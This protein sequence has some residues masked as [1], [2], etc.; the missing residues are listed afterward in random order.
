MN[1]LGFESLASSYLKA[2]NIP[3]K[4]VYLPLD[5]L[6]MKLG[7]TDRPL[8]FMSFRRSATIVSISWTVS[9]LIVPAV[10][11]SLVLHVSP[12][13]LLGLFPAE[14]LLQILAFNIVFGAAFGA[15]VG[16]R[17]R[18]VMVTH[19]IPPWEDLQTP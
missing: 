4:R 3:L 6:L 2:H 10:I 19:N 17:M 1:S 5:R 15:L 14:V 16:H 8:A 11:L 12:V 13:G 18:K 7:L 9:M